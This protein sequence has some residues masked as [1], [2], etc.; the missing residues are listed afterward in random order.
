MS[1]MAIRFVQT[2]EFIFAPFNSIY[3]P[4]FSNSLLQIQRLTCVIRSSHFQFPAVSFIGSPMSDW[5]DVKTED[6]NRPYTPSSVFDFSPAPMLGQAA[7]LP[8]S[9]HVF[10]TR[11]PAATLSE[12]QRTIQACDKCRERKTKVGKNAFL[13]ILALKIALVFWGSSRMPQMYNSWPY[14]SIFVSR[15]THAQTVE[16]SPSQRCVHNGPTL[17]V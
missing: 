10:Q 6:E 8:E 9:E 17:D 2:Q 5:S 13:S 7:S 4:L 12:R 15:V 16:G 11:P 3:N 1:Q 14:L